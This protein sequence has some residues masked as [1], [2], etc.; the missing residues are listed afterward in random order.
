MLQSP[1]HW[2][3]KIVLWLHGFVLFLTCLFTWFHQNLI[4]CKDIWRI[5]RFR[6]CF[7]IL[8]CRGF[9]QFC[10]FPIDEIKPMLI[11]KYLGEQWPERGKK[12]YKRDKRHQCLINA[13]LEVLPL[14]SSAF[15]SNSFLSFLIQEQIRRRFQDKLWHI[16]CYRMLTKCYDTKVRICHL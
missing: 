3:V 4:E 15:A 11:S 1:N 7:S 12:L 16:L 6:F 13:K 8:H 14:H 2:G 5:V 10:V 9:C